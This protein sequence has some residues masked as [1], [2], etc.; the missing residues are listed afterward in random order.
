MRATIS[1]P[2]TTPRSLY[3]FHVLVDD[4]SKREMSQTPGMLFL[5]TKGLRL[6]FL[7]ASDQCFSLSLRNLTSC[8]KLPTEEFVR[9]RRVSSP[10]IVLCIIHG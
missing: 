9:K 7:R 6:H 2:L 10:L 8:S 5:Y 3:N 4:S 1:L